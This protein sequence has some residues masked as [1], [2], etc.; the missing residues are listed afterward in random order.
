[1]TDLLAL[2]SIGKGTW[3][4]VGKLIKAEKWNNVYLLTTDFGVK[5]FNPGRKAEFVVVNFDDNLENIKLEIIKQLDKKLGMDTA[6]N[7]ASGTGKEHSALIAAALSLGTGIR[8]VT[9]KDDRMI[10]I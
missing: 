2:L 7:I 5:N 3:S 6:I 1:M 8:L 10:E 9:I 4:E